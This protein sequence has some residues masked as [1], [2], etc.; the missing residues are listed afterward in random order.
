MQGKLGWYPITV[1]SKKQST[2]ALS[3]GELAAALAGACDGLATTVELV[4]EMWMQCRGNEWSLSCD[5]SAVL[6]LI[7]RKGP[8][9]KTTHIE[10]KAFFLQRWSTRPEVRLVQVE[11]SEM[12]ADCL[13]KVRPKKIRSISRDSD[14]R[15]HPVLNR[16]EL[17]RKI[18]R[19]RAQKFQSEFRQFFRFSVVPC[20]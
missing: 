8:S 20:C 18:E 4:I 19:R 16:L 11:T 2:I 3:S 12:P 7:K 13:T 14:W 5:S 17:G 1:S 9:R 6:S 10:L 15:S